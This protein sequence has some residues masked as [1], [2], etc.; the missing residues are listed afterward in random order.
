MEPGK[1]ILVVVDEIG[2]IIEH[3][4]RHHDHVPTRL[5]THS[6]GEL[7]D[8]LRRNSFDA[9]IL[10]NNCCIPISEI[11][12][13]LEMAHEIRPGMKRIVLSGYTHEAF[14]RNCE[15]AG[16]DLFMAMPFR[17]DAF[18]GNLEMILHRPRQRMTID[19][20]N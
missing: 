20:G 6:V 16:A 11:G 15:S 17:R 9:L 19:F 8:T 13:A 14:T 5:T 10:T 2:D 1:R 3:Y 12:R 4:L 18:L 7:L